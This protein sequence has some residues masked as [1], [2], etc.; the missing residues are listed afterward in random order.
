LGYDG[1]VADQPEDD[2]VTSA[3][4][5]PTKSNQPP[6][7]EPIPSAISSGPFEI[8]RASFSDPLPSPRSIPPLA[9]ADYALARGRSGMPLTTIVAIGCGIFVVAV[10]L[11]VLLFI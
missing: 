2:V 8:D 5:D 1:T 3:A 4:K 7:R 9:P 11:V 6:P 10:A